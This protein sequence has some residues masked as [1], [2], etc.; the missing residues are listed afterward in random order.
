MGPL[1]VQTINKL[2]AAVQQ[3]EAAIDLF[4]AKRYAPAI[5]LAA[6]AEGCL[7][8]PGDRATDANGDLPGPEPLFQ[9]MKR[10]AAERHDIR[11]R[12]AVAIFNALVYW[13]KHETRDA[14]RT[15]E[16]SNF[17]AWTMIV[18]ALTK[19]E[20]VAPGRETPA[21]VQ[22]IEFSREHYSS[23]LGR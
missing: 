18:R 11:E 19:I 13:L 16:V 14:P 15:A 9:M 4:Y 17:D 22:F 5:T 21:I 2:D 8:Q 10:T 20:S 1:D 6:A 23:I 12:D 7:A 3:A